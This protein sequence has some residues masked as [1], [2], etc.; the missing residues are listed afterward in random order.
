MLVYEPK[1]HLKQQTNWLKPSHKFWNDWL[2]I[3]SKGWFTLAH[4]EA[5]TNTHVHESCLHWRT[6]AETACLLSADVALWQISFWIVSR[7]LP[8]LLFGWFTHQLSFGDG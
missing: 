8:C 5:R 3:Q 2:K 7:L 1:Q 6:Q 4:S